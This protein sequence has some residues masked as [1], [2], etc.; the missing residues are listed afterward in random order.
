[1]RR[2]S[3]RLSTIVQKLLK[4][5]FG[6]RTVKQVIAG[7]RAEV[8]D[9]LT[10]EVRS[11]GSDLGIEVVDVRIKRI[12][13]PSEVSTSVYERMAA[14]RK[15]VAKDFRSRGEEAAKIIRAAADRERAV[16]LAEAERDAQTI[17]GEGDAAAAE[18]YAN[19]YKQSPEFYSLYRSLNA[20]KHT[21][22]DRSDILLLQ[23]DAQFFRY[24]KDPSGGGQP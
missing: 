4:D 18:T 11:E 3:D 20:Y 17:R 7:Q 21:F 23:P 14:E 19:A 16:I 22:K 1:V 13:L 8:M 2:T 15:E 24:F 10:E 12:D 5:E 9:I 6:K